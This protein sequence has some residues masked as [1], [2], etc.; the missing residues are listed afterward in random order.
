MLSSKNPQ[1]Q[2]SNQE[3][4]HRLTIPSHLSQEEE[5]N[6]RQAELNSLLQTS[7][8][9]LETSS[10]TSRNTAYYEEI[11]Y[12]FL[13][14][15]SQGLAK[16]RAANPLY[17]ATTLDHGSP[18]IEKLFSTAELLEKSYKKLFE[19]KEKC[20]T[21]FWNN[22]LAVTNT[23][24]AACPENLREAKHIEYLPAANDCLCLHKLRVIALIAA[25]IHSELLSRPYFKKYAGSRY[26][27]PDY[28]ILIY[29][30][31]DNFA[32]KS[33]RM[34]LGKIKSLK[35]P[36]LV[37]QCISLDCIDVGR[38]IKDLVQGLNRIIDIHNIEGLKRNWIFPPTAPYR[39]AALFYN[40]DLSEVV[41]LDTY[42]K[43]SCAPTATF[44]VR[45]VIDPRPLYKN[46][47]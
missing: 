35:N 7:L 30:G 38:D 20:S 44:S 1:D 5:F 34:D 8:D 43:L 40:S 29:P 28:K 23:L 2:H 21:P 11:I 13:L 12:D 42:P 33:H 36:L 6:I 45:K 46:W 31:S 10:Q 3:L 27:T 26:N 14:K 15:V 19:I 24:F 32:S 18:D 22:A 37:A 17:S 9:E 41:E 4:D 39:F 25:N 16:H 47:L